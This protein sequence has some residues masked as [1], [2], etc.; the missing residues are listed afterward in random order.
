MTA[1]NPSPSSLPN[2][3]QYLRVFRERYP[4]RLET[5]RRA[6]EVGRFIDL[7]WPGHCFVS[8]T[9]L[10]FN[11]L[12]DDGHLWDRHAASRL[13]ITLEV[14]LAGGFAAWSM[15]RGVFRFDRDAFE[16][17]FNTSLDGDIPV[18]LL[19]RLPHWC[20]YI[21]LPDLPVDGGNLRGAFAWLN[22]D[23][24]SGEDTLEILWDA[25]EGLLPTPLPLVGSLDDGIRAVVE[26]G[27]AELARDGHRDPETAMTEAVHRAYSRELISGLVNLLLYLA[28]DEPDYDA[29]DVPRKPQARK[30]KKGRRLFQASGTRTW[31]VGSRVGAMLRS[32]RRRT[33]GAPGGG[34]HASPRGHIRAA[35]W[36]RYWAGPLGGQRELRVHWIPPLPVNLDEGDHPTVYRKVA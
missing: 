24:E 4:G 15:T 32:S 34:T 11:F 16:V 19:R 27:G 3:D 6:H 26:W 7:T 36:H 21:E 28:S 9:V 35:H 10:E 25:G 14:H 29:G 30:T 33:V 18:S 8:T 13:G 1:K 23:L 31:G 17:L 22:F 20:V 12:A 5:A 2:P